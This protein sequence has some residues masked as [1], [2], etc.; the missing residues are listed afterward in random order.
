MVEKI[1]TLDNVS[2]IDFLGVENKNIKEVATA[3]PE[4]KIISRGNQI[5]IKGTPPEIVKIHDILNALLDHYH[6]YGEVTQDNVVA[7]LKEQDEPMK[8]PE[9]KGKRKYWFLVHE[10][11]G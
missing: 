9:K 1:I 2:L 7:Y 4:S 8:D 11:P 3:F 5:R 6:Q 10:E